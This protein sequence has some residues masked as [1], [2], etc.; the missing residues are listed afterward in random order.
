MVAWLDL[1]VELLAV[2]VGPFSMLQ[3]AF[4]NLF[5]VAFSSLNTKKKKKSLVLLQLDNA[6]LCWHLC[7]ICPFLNRGGR[8][9][10][11]VRGE[12]DGGTVRRE[13]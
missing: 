7:E 4:G 5:W 2:G 12:V 1:P 10:E 11:G 3:L 8:V 13:M 9:G 6:M